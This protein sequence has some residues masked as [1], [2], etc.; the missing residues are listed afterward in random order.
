MLRG[1]CAAYLYSLAYSLQ[2]RFAGSQ[3]H[4]RIGKTV[5]VKR[6][7]NSEIGHV[8]IVHV[9]TVQHDIDLNMPRATQWS[10]HLPL[11]DGTIEVSAPGSAERV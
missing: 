1:G 10:A 6:G 5:A 4:T 3:Q 9:R 11:P 2:T 8:T 7:F